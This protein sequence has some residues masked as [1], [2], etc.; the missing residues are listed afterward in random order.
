VRIEIR[1]KNYVSKRV[2]VE[3]YET[4]YVALS[5]SGFHQKPEYLSSGVSRYMQR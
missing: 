5:P 2:D 3:G 1:L 4:E